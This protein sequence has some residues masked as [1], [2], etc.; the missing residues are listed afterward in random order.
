MLKPGILAEGAECFAAFFDGMFMRL[1]YLRKEEM[2]F[3]L[4]LMLDIELLIFF[5]DFTGRH[6]STITDL[7]DEKT[8]KC[9]H[10]Y[11]NVSKKV[12]SES[13]LI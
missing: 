7:F 5:Y 8:G 10:Y 2:Y 4:I 1:P 13:Q 11:K 6:F 3:Q 9:N 12:L